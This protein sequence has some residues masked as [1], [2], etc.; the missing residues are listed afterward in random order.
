MGGIKAVS[1]DMD[2]TLFQPT[3]ADEVWH[4][5]LPR[6][7]ARRLGI[8]LEEAKRVVESEYERVGDERREWYDLEFW[9]LKFG[10]GVTK[11]EIFS[12]CGG[13][14]KLYPEAR[15]V[16]EALFKRF[17]LVICTNAPK[18]F[19]QFQLEKAGI[20]DMFFRVYSALTDFGELKKCST[21]QRILSELGLGP[22][23]LVHVGDH[24]KFDLEVPRSFGI[25]SYLMDRTGRFTGDYVIRD[26]R[27][28]EAKLDLLDPG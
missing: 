23:E 7:Y 17:R 8:P 10:L 24:P 22:E 6:L 13:K 5:H 28:L 21:F 18:E 11:E 4:E 2:G 15:G 3:F 1:F 19:A 26:L 16:L 14:V 20:R 9:I 12:A 27:E 25:R